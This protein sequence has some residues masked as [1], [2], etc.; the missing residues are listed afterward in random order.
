MKVIAYRLRPDGSA[1]ADA[2]PTTMKR[3]KFA[4]FAHIYGGGLTQPPPGYG[5]PPDGFSL[6]R[7]A[8]GEFMA[9]RDEA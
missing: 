6:W 2:F 9:V 3:L 7:T 1:L 5:S 4:D 8:K